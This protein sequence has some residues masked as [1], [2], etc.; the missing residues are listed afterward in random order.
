MPSE[1][2]APSQAEKQRIPK[3]LRL[4][5]EGA[6]YLLATISQSCRRTLAELGTIVVRHPA[7]M[8]ETKIECDIRNS[9][10]RPRLGQPVFELAQ[11]DMLQRLRNR[12]AKM[13]FEADL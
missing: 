10:V 6:I 2:G 3:A 7:E 9:I 11:S 13:T 4:A 1:G 8:A 12:N 5:M